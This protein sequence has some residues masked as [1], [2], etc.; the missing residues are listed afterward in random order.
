[1]NRL[2]LLLEWHQRRTGR[3]GQVVY[4]VQLRGWFL[5]LVAGLVD[6]SGS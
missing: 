1:M 4:A 5:A 2:G 6:K 3:E